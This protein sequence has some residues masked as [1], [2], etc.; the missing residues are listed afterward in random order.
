MDR[1]QL[2]CAWFDCD[3]C[4]WQSLAPACF[5]NP[6]RVGGFG[7]R[8]RSHGKFVLQHIPSIE[9]RPRLRCASSRLRNVTSVVARKQRSVLRVG[10]CV[11]LIFQEI[12]ENKFT[13]ASQLPL[14]IGR[15]HLR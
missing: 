5:A 15:E 1:D 4:A 10:R 9:Y 7:A 12:S 3:L 11:A 2:R 14:L 8:L 13:L 6:T